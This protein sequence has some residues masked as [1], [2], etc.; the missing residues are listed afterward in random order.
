MKQD[1]RQILGAVLPAALL[2]L[3]SGCV[4][5]NVG[6]PETFVHRDTVVDG[7]EP[8]HAVEVLSV[9]GQAKPGNNSLEAWLEADVRR[10]SWQRVHDSTV[11]VKTQKRLAVGLFPGLGEA[12]LK[13]SGALDPIWAPQYPVNNS[14]QK[15]EHC[16]YS[17]TTSGGYNC[18]LDY[19]GLNVGC[20]VACLGVP[21]AIGT[22][23]TLLVE[24][25][26]GWS[27]Y[28]DRYDKS[29]AKTFHSWGNKYFVDASFS[30]KLQLLLR[31]T[32]EERARMGFTTCF[33]WPR[34]KKQSSVFEMAQ[35][36]LVGCHKHLAVFVEEG[37]EAERRVE[38]E[39]RERKTVPGPYEATLRVPG[40]GIEKTVRVEEGGSKAVFAL[41]AAERGGTYEAT[42]EFRP[43]HAG[44]DA[45]GRGWDTQTLRQ[46][47]WLQERPKPAPPLNPSSAA[48]PEIRYVEKEIHHYHETRVVEER[49]HGEMPWSIELTEPF[50]NGR[51]EYR[52]AILDGSKTP[53]EVERE[54][55]PQIEQNLRDAFEASMPGMDPQWV[56]AYAVAEY[57]GRSIRFKGVAFSVQPVTDGWR[58][59][60]RTRRGA[61]RLRMSDGMTP[62][63]A[64]RWARENIEAIAR[65]KNTA[66]EAGKDPP[67]GAKFRSLSEVLENSVL[68]VEFE[69][70]E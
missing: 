53:A 42:V 59:D 3:G 15:T 65:E 39:S 16:V 7:T 32:P 22:L 20:L 18:V 21:Q 29:R 27:C 56:R 47:V 37:R 19:V 60:A 9:N 34:K 28:H 66:V 25:F 62:E 55:K 14:P 48:Q 49:T 10:V 38:K 43:L 50:R 24:P 52:V 46:S 8:P 35:F 41:P 6:Q 63:E 44:T 58:Y 70:V 11:T 67:A 30:P 13:P 4:A 61:V 1:W 36:G 31:F 64:K 23:G 45:A 69:A 54:V 5:V 68:T 2:A 40:A 57:E 51:A 12:I 17:A 26:C 33:D